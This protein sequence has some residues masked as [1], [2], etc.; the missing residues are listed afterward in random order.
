MQG[1]LRSQKSASLLELG[2][3]ADELHNMKHPGPAHYSVNAAGH[4]PAPVSS[5][6]QAIVI[7]SLNEAVNNLQLE[8]YG[9]QQP[10][11]AP[12]GLLLFRP[13]HQGRPFSQAHLDLRNCS[14]VTPT[15]RFSSSYQKGS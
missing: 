6:H 3:L 11:Q 4:M 9:Y 10:N 12:A 15:C 5:P 2:E 14:S 1:V 7:E 13:L 8:D